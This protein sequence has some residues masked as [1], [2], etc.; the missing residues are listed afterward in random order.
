MPRKPPDDILIQITVHN[1]G[2]EAAELHVLPTL[3]FRNQWSWHAGADRPTLAQL[4]TSP[5]AKAVVKAVD[6]KLGKRLLY[7]DGDV[8][9]A[10]HGERNQHAARIFGVP[11]RSPYVKDSINNYVVHGQEGAVNPEKTGTKAA[12]HYR[13]DASVRA[14]RR[15]VRLRL[16]YLAPRRVRQTQGRTASLPFGSPFDEGFER[17]RKEADEFYAAITPSSLSADEANVMRQ[18]L[19]G[20]LWSK[21]F[22][23]Y[24]VDKWLEERG[25]DP[26]KAPRKAARATTTGTTCTTAT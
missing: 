11:N 21:Q 18:A 17:R 25:S 4:G 23:H 19:A 8:S 3:W 9:A 22:Y 2:P 5:P 14:M 13:A 16:R 20:M 1:R 7:C 12:A 15:V 24:D 6:P 26:F 10:V